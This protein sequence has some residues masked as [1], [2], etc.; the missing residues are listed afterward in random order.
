MTARTTIDKI[1]F[2]T[3]LFQVQSI[4]NQ[5][6]G[7]N[8]H[9]KQQG[10]PEV[11]RLLI[12]DAN[13]NDC[14]DRTIYHNVPNSF[15]FDIT[16]NRQGE[17]TATLS[18]NPKHYDHDIE[19]A[20]IYIDGTLKD[21]CGIEIDWMKE[22][23]IHRIDLAGDCTMK[24]E[25]RQYRDAIEML[26]KQRYSKEKDITIYPNSMLYAF[27]DWQKCIYDRGLKNLI[28]T[29][30][31]QL[32][33]STNEMRDELR[34]IKKRSINGW[35][36]IYSFADVLNMDKTTL[37]KRRVD[38]AMKF[39]EQSA[40]KT[41]KNNHDI[42]T[43]YD[44][45]S[46]ITK[47]YRNKREQSLMFLASYQENEIEYLKAKHYFQECIRKDAEMK[48]WKSRSAK[49]HHIKRG[50]EAFN[51]VMQEIS[52]NRRQLTKDTKQT[53]SAKMDEYTSKFLVA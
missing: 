13:G 53:I 31:K 29:G 21:K 42:E 24:H 19:R 44:L 2:S 6:L 12:T 5:E 20:M 14:F 32:P 43:I 8:R 47:Q 48:E 1:V 49:S 27:T 35:M 17:P 37:N 36:E 25:T 50:I 9:N 46:N 18:F 22:T 41:T 40:V 23:K 33:S 16:R 15:N 10:E 52:N 11:E 3:P 30:A 28:D 7:M 34:L 38:L 26:M 4:H 51:K 45:Y 39:I